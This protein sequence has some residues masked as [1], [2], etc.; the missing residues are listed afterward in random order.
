MA[1][2]IEAIERNLAA[3]LEKQRRDAITYT[4]LIVLATPVFV[5]I[6]ALA[7]VALSGYVLMHL[8]RS[9]VPNTILFYT[10]VSAFL[11]YM[12][13]FV[14]VHSSRSMHEFTLEPAWIAGTVLF[15]VL[16]TLTY[17]TSILRT[18]PVLF[19]IA[20]TLAGL[21]ILGLIGQVKLPD[22]IA[23]MP[24]GEN[25][26]LTL[27][28]A[29]SAFIVTAYGQILGSSWLW[30]SPQPDELRLG[31]W[32]LCKLA[33]DPDTAISSDALT[34]PMADL[35]VRLQLIGV[36]PGGAALTP[37]GLAFVRSAE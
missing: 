16:L 4:V 15:V 9:T 28:L 20:Y 23:Q 17:G 36:T 32:F 26:F 5:A 35:L 34:G 22:D 7:V 25:L 12:I 18:H 13:V 6:T 27:I 29:V 8:W 37:K 10:G 33:A 21:L 24:Q 1:E 19:G 14:L 11:A 30:R 2:H 31:A 3:M